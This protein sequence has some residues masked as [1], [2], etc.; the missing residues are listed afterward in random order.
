MQ[1]STTDADSTIGSV[2]ERAPEEHVASVSVRDRI[3]QSCALW[4]AAAVHAASHQIEEIRTQDE[5][6]EK[7]ALALV[8]A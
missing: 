6:A 5:T 1:P 2:E 7:A 4:E 8:A 3:L